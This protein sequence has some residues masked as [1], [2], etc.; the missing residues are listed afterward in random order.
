MK[1]HGTRCRT[2]EAR[3][4]SLDS[5]DKETAYK[6]VI[7]C[8]LVSDPDVGNRRRGVGISDVSLSELEAIGHGRLNSDN[9]GDPNLRSDCVGGFGTKELEGQYR[10]RYWPS[11]IKVVTCA[12]PWAQDGYSIKEY[13]NWCLDVCSKQNSR[14]NTSMQPD[15]LIF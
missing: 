14:S 3:G 11:A 10:W 7:R 13:L 4:S 9:T 12:R 8:R 2:A 6:D 15:I 5:S 1:H